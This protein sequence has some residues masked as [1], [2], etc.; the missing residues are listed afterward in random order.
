MTRFLRLFPQFAALESA[1][2]KWP[3]REVEL[4]AS[5]ERA[6]FELDFW[7]AKSAQQDAE[8]ARLNALLIDE[9]HKVADTMSVH[10]IGKRVFSK[11]SEQPPAAAGKPVHPPAINQRQARATMNGVMSDRRMFQEMWDS[12]PANDEKN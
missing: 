8:I 10:A 1:A 6:D 11:A 3:A 12:L 2:A 5:R 7:K 4:I 9:A